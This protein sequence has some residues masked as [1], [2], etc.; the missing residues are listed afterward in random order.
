MADG[1]TARRSSAERVAVAP[2][3]VAEGVDHTLR[4]SPGERLEH[5]FEQRCDATPDKI[6]VD[7]DGAVVTF[8]HLD[9]AANRLARHLVASGVTSGARV[10]LLLDDPVQTYVGMLGVLKAGAAYVPLDRAFPPDRVAYVVGDAGVGTVL[11]LSHLRGNVGEVGAALLCL[12]E[13][14]RRS[15]PVTAPGSPPVRG[16]TPIRWRT[17]S[18]PRA[19]PGGP[20]AWRSS[21]RA[22]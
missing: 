2:V 13:G 14:A 1:S 20:R 16:D 15:R 17:S 10:A 5:L 22:S 8:A 18:T 12:D 9:A 6:A 7:A 3:L 21:T 4:W 11:T 19:R